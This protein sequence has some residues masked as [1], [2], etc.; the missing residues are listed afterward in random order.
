MADD[1][2]TYNA[3]VVVA[4]AE[5]EGWASRPVFRNGWYVI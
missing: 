2:H 4:N 1:L 3:G 5:A